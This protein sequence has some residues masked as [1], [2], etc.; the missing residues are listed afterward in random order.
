MSSLPTGSR[1]RARRSPA[2]VAVFEGVPTPVGRRTGLK[3]KRARI[4]PTPAW[5]PSSSEMVLGRSRRILG[6]PRASDRTTRDESRGAARGRERASGGSR[7]LSSDVRERRRVRFSRRRFVGGRATRPRAARR[8]RRCLAAQ[9]RLRRRRSAASTASPR[10]CARVS[11]AKSRRRPRRNPS[12]RPR[13]RTGPLP[14]TH[15][16]AF[17]PSRRGRSR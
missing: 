7:S 15:P 13:P 17:L 11:T 1:C 12:R 6:A 14:R 16:R 4:L 5:S 2:R 3:I 8:A 9:T 10:P